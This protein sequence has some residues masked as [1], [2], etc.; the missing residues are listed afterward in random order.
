[1]YRNEQSDDYG[2]QSLAQVYIDWAMRW[3]DTDNYAKNISRCE[4]VISEGLRSVNKR[5]SLLLV[6]S[7]LEHILGDQPRRIEL[8]NRA[9][10]ENPASVICRYLLAREAY[11]RNDYDKVI[12]LLRP[13]IENR[14]DEIRSF[15]LFA[16]AISIKERNYAG[17]I[18]VL[19]QADPIAWS[20]PTFIATLG[21]M[22]SLS[23][24][25][26]EADNVFERAKKQRF[27]EEEAR[28][29]AF[30]PTNLDDPQHDVTTTG[31]VIVIKGG[32]LLIQ[33]Q[34]YGKFLFPSPKI[35]GSYVKPR[36]F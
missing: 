15:I 27:P 34:Q 16:K 22:Y 20:D 9:L 10:K 31:N 2:Y 23:G 30:H 36:L 21:G 32:Y 4:E 28:Q 12:C 17:A 19:K 14:F 1:M 25:A 3:D 7:N 35:K 8:L 6:S 18:A 5:E 33:S 29:I 26:S 13:T 24:N 11:Q